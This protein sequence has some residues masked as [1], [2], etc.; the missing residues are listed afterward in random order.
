MEGCC[1]EIYSR[2]TK[3]ITVFICSWWSRRV[4]VLLFGPRHD[5][6][7]RGGEGR[8]E[9]RGEGRKLIFMYIR[10]I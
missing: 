3:F 9:R 2:S 10:G 7:E 8:G 1:R 6:G 4:L 5:E